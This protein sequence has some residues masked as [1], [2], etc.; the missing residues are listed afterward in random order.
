MA[1]MPT[2]VHCPA[3]C[4]QRGVTAVSAGNHAVATAFA[5]RSVGTSAKVVMP[6]TANPTRIA[7]CHAYGAEVVLAENTHDAFAQVKRIE[8]E[9]GRHFIPTFEGELR[10]ETNTSEI[11]SLMRTSYAV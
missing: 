1:S 6:R 7:L 5:A 3:S 8:A 4:R 2:R 11:K 10:S 9:E